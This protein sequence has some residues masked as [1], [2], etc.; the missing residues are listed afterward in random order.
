MSWPRGLC[1]GVRKHLV[2]VNYRTNAW[3]DWSNFSVAYWGWL[4]EGSF[5]WSAH[6]RSWIWFPSISGQT[7][8]SIDPD[9]S[10]AYWGWL[11]EGSFRW[12]A[13]P[14]SWIWFPS[15]RGQT[16]G[17][18]DPDFS[19][20]YWGWL[21]EGSFRWSDL[22]SQSSMATVILLHVYMELT[23][24]PYRRG[25]IIFWLQKSSKGLAL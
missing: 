21:E 13:H 16:P 2:S 12:S 11:E 5:R 10:A 8:G 6:P 22:Q 24:Y 4:E 17:S 20:A 7:P 3:V 19:A 14:R 18:I 25:K 1:V 15:I 9:F 23:P